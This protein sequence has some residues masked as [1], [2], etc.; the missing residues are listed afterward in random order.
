M[1][2]VLSDPHKRDN[3]LILLTCTYLL[4][5]KNNLAIKYRDE[6]FLTLTKIEIEINFKVRDK[7]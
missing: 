2:S 6:N 5:K 1:L 4:L 7:K 3:G